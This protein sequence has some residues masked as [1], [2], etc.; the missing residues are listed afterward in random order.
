M[1][2]FPELG[3]HCSLDRCRKLGK[4]HSGNLN[5]SQFTDFMPFLCK[6]CR[7]FYCGEHRF[8]HT[9]KPTENQVLSVTKSDDGKFKQFLC[10]KNACFEMEWIKMLC[11]YC[12]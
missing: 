3:V 9:C 2:E 8:D 12:D 1:A 7:S 11:S 10:S 4:C 6:L 5:N